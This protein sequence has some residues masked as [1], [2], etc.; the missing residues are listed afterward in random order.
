MTGIIETVNSLTG[1]LLSVLGSIMIAENIVKWFKKKLLT[2]HKQIIKRIKE[3]E[4][5]KRGKEV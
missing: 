4:K 1:T 2:K 3:H 5:T